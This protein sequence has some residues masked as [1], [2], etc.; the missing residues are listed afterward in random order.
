MDWL[1]LPIKVKAD[2]VRDYLKS[3]EEAG[4]EVATH[5]LRSGQ[6]R[7]LVPDSSSAS[8]REHFERDMETLLDVFRNDPELWRRS[9]GSSQ[10]P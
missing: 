8:Q 4:A 3:L 1:G 9:P 7:N 6:P 5:W 2:D 10:S